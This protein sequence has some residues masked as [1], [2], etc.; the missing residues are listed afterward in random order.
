MNKQELIEQIDE[1]KQRIEVLEKEVKSNKDEEVKKSL[2]QKPKKGEVYYFLDSAGY[3]SHT[4]WTNSE[5]DLFRFNTGN[6]FKTEQ[7]AEEYKENLL[8]KQVLKDL[9]LEL[10]DGIEIYWDYFHQPKYYILYD[11]RFK[12]LLI[13]FT[14]TR[15]CAP[16]IYCISP[17]FL[18]V[19]KDHIG[20]EKLIKFLKSGL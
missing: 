19:A 12:E 13:D 2:R 5:D 18:E 4:Y 14:R 6:C 3:V 11:Y 1:L 7:E 15:P 10:N 8:T 16:G 17:N 9:A 20:E